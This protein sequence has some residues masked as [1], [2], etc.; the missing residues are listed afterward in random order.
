[1]DCPYQRYYAQQAGAGIGAIYRGAPYQRGHGIGS[2]LGGVFRSILPLFKAG[3]RAVG[4]EALKTGSNFLGDLVENRPA[5]EAFQGRLK[6]AGQN[7]KRRADH[8]I[9]SIMEGSGYKR[10]RTLAI[11]QLTSRRS[12]KPSKT[13]TG[14]RVSYSDIFSK[15]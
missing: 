9:N 5:K 11:N 13:K 12:K 7:L 6:E 15:N 14:S 2:F 10:P 8:K 4:H 1:M 3:A